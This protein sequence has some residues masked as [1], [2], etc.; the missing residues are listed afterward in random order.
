MRFK[1]VLKNLFKQLLIS[2]EYQRHFMYYR[3]YVD[4]L[5]VFNSSIATQYRSIMQLCLSCFRRL[6]ISFKVNSS[7]NY[8]LQENYVLKGFKRKR[9]CTLQHSLGEIYMNHG[10]LQ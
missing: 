7:W 5:S 6:C 10:E 1:F 3:G 9:S 4:V 2:S 8:K